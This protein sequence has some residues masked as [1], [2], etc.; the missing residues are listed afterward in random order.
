MTIWSMRIV[1]C[2]TKAKNMYSEYSIIIASAQQQWL[3]DSAS[4]LRYMYIAYL[5]NLNFWH[6]SFTFKF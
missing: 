1:R 4:L 6:Q 5:V 3:H 2:I